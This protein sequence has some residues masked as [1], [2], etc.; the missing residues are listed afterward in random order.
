MAHTVA[1]AQPGPG[2]GKTSPPGGDVS[3][4]SSRDGYLRAIL[5]AP[6]E[7]Q[8]IYRDGLISQKVAAAVAKLNVPFGR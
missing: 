5:R 2:R 4:N 8:K 1:P 6:V 7:V 3:S